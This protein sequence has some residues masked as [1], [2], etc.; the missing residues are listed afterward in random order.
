MKKN[1]LVAMSIVLSLSFSS[2]SFADNSSK[3]ADIIFLDNEVEKAVK[4][5]RSRSSDEEATKLLKK[6]NPQGSSSENNTNQIAVNFDDIS[7]NP[8]YSKRAIQHFKKGGI[9]YF[10]GSDIKLSDVE[11]LLGIVVEERPNHKSSDKGAIISSEEEKWQIVGIDP[12]NPRKPYLR[13]I[14]NVVSDKAEPSINLKNHRDIFVQ[15]VMSI[16]N[17]APFKSNDISILDYSSDPNVA[18]KYNITKTIYQNSTKVF[19]Q[20]VFWILHQ[21]KESDSDP[22]YDYFYIEHSV[23]TNFY[24]GARVFSTSSGGSGNTYDIIHSLPYS[25]DIQRDFAPKSTSSSSVFTVA[26]PWAVQWQ[27][28]LNSSASLT[29]TG[30]QSTGIS[31]F[32]WKPTWSQSWLQYPATYKPGTAWAS[33]GSSTAAINLEEYI[34]YTYDSKTYSDTSTQEV[35]YYY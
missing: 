27:F 26:L 35:R 2:S 17:E 10:Y 9:I 14:K 7:S 3:K 15:E 28:S 32:S 21:N 22:N 29:S 25:T 19:Y 23:E 13:Q 18:S 8:S 31:K 30:S 1:V 33:K 5:L 12:N 34:V 6:F 20:N 24:N 11:S 16:V 4:E